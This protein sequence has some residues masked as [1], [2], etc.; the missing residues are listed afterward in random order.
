MKHGPRALPEAIGNELVA[1]YSAGKWAQLVV[2]ADRVTARHPRYLL[3]WRAS[4]KAFLQLQRFPEAIDR[5]SRVVELAPDDADG[6]N[7]LGN[8][9]HGIGRLEDAT[10]SYRRALALSPNSSDACSNFGR[11]LCAQGQFDEAAAFCQRA[12]DIDPGAATAHNNLGT[13]LREAGRPTDAE[14][15][16]RRALALRPDYLEAL[17]NLGTILV[18]LGHWADAM[19]TYR[20]AV[21]MHPDSGVAYNALGRTL[22]RLAD[23]DDEA[24]RCL[25][26]AITLN[27]YDTTTYAELGNILM[28]KR[29]LDAALAM[30]RRAQELQP[31]ITW[32]ANQAKAEFSAVFL[33]TPMGGSTPVDYLAG[34]AGYDRHFHCVIPDTPVNVDLLRGKADV[35]FNMISNVDDGEDSLR[36]AV[37]LVERLGR[38]TINH[39]VLI[40]Q[41][42]R[43][44]VA[45][46]LADIPHCVVPKTVRLAG[47]V[48]AAAALTGQYA[49]FGLPML[50]RIAGRHGGDDFEKFDDWEAIADFVSRSPGANYY[51][52]EYVNYRSVDGFFRK[53]RIIFI[54]GELFPYHLAIHDDWMVHHFRT[55]MANHAWMRKEEERF[56]DDMGGV[57]NAACQGS[58]RAVANAT[59]LDYGGIDCGVDRDGRIVVFE[60]NASMLIHDEKNEDF[61][62]KNQY[63]AKIK[64]AFDAMLSRRRVS[65]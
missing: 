8:A 29:R 1:L 23:D 58:L 33:D 51:L 42:D 2:A 61:A 56:L 7:D 20:L 13:A 41:T 27:A 54:D 63:V 52:I 31:F 10:P 45:R 40:M 49:G 14:A 18:E 19:S 17:I 36:L 62:Y 50:V 60:V 43:E 44:T 9:L 32:R 28:R 48:V 15:A 26:R 22:S 35:I 53:Y 37:D 55:D 16:Y 24:A 21:A 30:F 38:P 11:L 4:G 46:R 47:P 59:E 25:E 65:V 39:P 5:L 57:F 6:H 64:S 34:R 3:G 12:I